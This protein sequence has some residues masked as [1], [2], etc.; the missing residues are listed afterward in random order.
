MKNVKLSSF[1]VLWGGKLGVK[2]IKNVR[3]SS[4]LGFFGGPAGDKIY[5][6]RA[7]VVIFGVLGSKDRQEL[8]TKTTKDA[9]LSSFSWSWRPRASKSS[10]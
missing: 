4:F 6:K 7:T 3:L 8:E 5:E 9:K 10:Y 1:L 2:S